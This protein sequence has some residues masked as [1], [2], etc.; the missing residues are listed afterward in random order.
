MGYKELSMKYS[1]LAY[2]IDDKHLSSMTQSK[3]NY[4]IKPKKS[5]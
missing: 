4:L 3:I 2:E 5:K 1:Q